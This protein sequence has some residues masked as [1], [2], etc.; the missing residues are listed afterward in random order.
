MEPALLGNLTELVSELFN[1]EFNFEEFD[2]PPSCV[3]MVASDQRSSGAVELYLSAESGFKLIRTMWNSLT[4]QS[5]ASEK[6]LF[7]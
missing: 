1:F 6:V 7:S 5:Q 2:F 4:S 3:P